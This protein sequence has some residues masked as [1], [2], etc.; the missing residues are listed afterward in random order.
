[1]VASSSRRLAVA[2]GIC[3]ILWVVLGQAFFALFPLAAGGTMLPLAGGLDA[4]VA[5]WAELGQRPAVAALEWVRVGLA[6]LLWPFFL[7]LC[8]LMVRRGQGDVSLVAVG[9]G[10]LSMILTVISDITNATP[11]HALAQACVDAGSPAQQAAIQST[12]NGL[13]IWRCGLNRASGLLYQACA[14]LFG[15]SMVLGRT[16]RGWGWV[17]LVGAVVA[18][19]S[20]LSLGLEVPTNLLWTGL[21]YT[22][23]PLAV[24]IC[25]LRLP[26]ELARGR[27]STAPAA[28]RPAPGALPPAEE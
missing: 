3:A 5:R 18:I 8:R 12:L 14:G 1:M 4:E 23:W 9:L 15:L 22:L 2:G 19:P 25:L 27:A 10:V 6:L 26:G 11:S 13:F 28:E 24:G 20:K 21:V 17:A 16:W 7:A